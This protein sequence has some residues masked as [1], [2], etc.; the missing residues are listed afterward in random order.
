MVKIKNSQAT[1]IHVIVT[2]NVA[3]EAV[4]DVDLSGVV[5]IQIDESI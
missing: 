5:D 4:I 3:P 2:I 1:D